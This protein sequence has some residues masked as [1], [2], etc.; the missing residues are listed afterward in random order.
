MFRTGGGKEAQDV[1]C[2]SQRSA[3]LD[4]SYSHE[5]FWKLDCKGTN[6]RALMVELLTLEEVFSW[7]EYVEKAGGICPCWGRKE[8]WPE[9]QWE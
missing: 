8:I 6:L 7:R 1:F 5:I 9:L 3:T 2:F 4:S